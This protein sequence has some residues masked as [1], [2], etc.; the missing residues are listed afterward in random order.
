M[1]AAFVS[2]GRIAFMIV[3]AAW[4]LTR[5]LGAAG[6]IVDRVVTAFDAFTARLRRRKIRLVA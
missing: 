3:G 1:I 5:F 4:F 6:P 2:V